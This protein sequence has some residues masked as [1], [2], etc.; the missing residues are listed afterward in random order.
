MHRADGGDI[1]Y[2]KEVTN[3]NKNNMKQITKAIAVAF[4]N[5]SLIA[6]ITVGL[7]L[8]YAHFFNCE[9]IWQIKEYLIGIVV[10]LALAAIL[11]CS[12]YFL[13]VERLGDK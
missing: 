13:I 2:Q 6:F 3:V 12:Y 7:L 5:L 10:V 9:G 8:R 1:I 4:L 11:S